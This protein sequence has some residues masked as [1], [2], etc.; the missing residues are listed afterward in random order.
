M[1]RYSSI[2][3]SRAGW[4]PQDLMLRSHDADMTF[5]LYITGMGGFVDSNET[6]K[7]RLA[8]ERLTNALR[9]LA[10]TQFVRVSECHP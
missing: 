7:L 8:N 6:E 1:A 4:H 5:A 3:A 2:S 9:V 10:V